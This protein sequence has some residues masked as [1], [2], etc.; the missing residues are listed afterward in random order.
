MI[1]LLMEKEK[2]MTNIYS[3]E[4]REEFRIHPEV[5]LRT[6]LAIVGDKERKQEAV[7]R[8]VQATGTSPGEVEAIMT[9]TISI[10]LNQTRSN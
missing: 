5:W 6:L 9:T 8:V 10:L 4:D 2:R 1:L 7:Q 3:F